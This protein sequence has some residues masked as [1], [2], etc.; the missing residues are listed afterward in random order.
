MLFQE[1]TAYP[2]FFEKPLLLCATFACNLLRSLYLKN[3]FIT[4]K[5]HFELMNTAKSLLEYVT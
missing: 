2:A 5:V 4:R 1:L 3:D